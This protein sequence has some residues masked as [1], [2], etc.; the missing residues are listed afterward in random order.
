MENPARVALKTISNY[1][2]IST[3]GLST[4]VFQGNMRISAEVNAEADAHH[5][6]LK[7]RTMADQTAKRTGAGH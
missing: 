3:R 4:P 5:C 7:E 6:L 2:I 1:S